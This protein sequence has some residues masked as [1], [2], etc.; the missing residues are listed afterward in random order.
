M[1]DASAITSYLLEQASREKVYNVM[2][3][4]LEGGYRL[5][6]VDLAFFEVANALW[7]ACTLRG[8]ID[9]EAVYLS[10][11]SLYG[12][13]LEPLRQERDLMRRAA[14][15][16]LE[17]GLSVY[18]SIYVSVAERERAFIFTLDEKQ[19]RVAERY[20]HVHMA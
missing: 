8:L 15:I 7:R 3:D 13:P 14:E 1:L 2:R 12:L 10:L 11:D 9:E 6:T 19:G 16:S 17:S 20:V 18:D 4:T 5:L